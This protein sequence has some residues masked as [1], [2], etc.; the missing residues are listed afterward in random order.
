MDSDSD[1]E[2]ES[3][4][5]PEIEETEKEHE[6]DE[7]EPKPYNIKFNSDDILKTGEEYGDDC[8]NN[9]DILKTGEEYYEDDCSNNDKFDGH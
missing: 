2:I 6:G 7:V 8:C 5:G 1:P 3:H 4:D 9:D